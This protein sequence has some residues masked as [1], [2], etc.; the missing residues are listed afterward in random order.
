MIIDFRI[1]GLY[2]SI[3]ERTAILKLTASQQYF[4]LNSTCK[5]LE[6]QDFLS[7]PLLL[8]IVG[9]SIILYIYIYD[10]IHGKMG[11]IILFDFFKMFMKLH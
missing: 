2:I 4:W 10:N 9:K 5:E 8:F 1:E 6:K 7:P 3:G 11:I